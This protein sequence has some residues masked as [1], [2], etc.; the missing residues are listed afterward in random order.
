[1]LPTFAR[2]GVMR[3]MLIKLSSHGNFRE[4]TRSCTYT[5]LFQPKSARS[6]AERGGEKKIMG[7][8]HLHELLIIMPQSI[9]S[10]ARTQVQILVSIS[11]PHPHSLAMAQHKVGTSVHR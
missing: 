8:T 3:R 6:A 9:H 1:M 2:V 11:V 5:H 4:K 7:I 10:D